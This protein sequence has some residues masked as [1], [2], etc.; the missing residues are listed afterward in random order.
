MAVEISLASLLITGV[1]RRQSGQLN[2]RFRLRS[3]F[4]FAV[5]HVKVEELHE[6]I[7]VQFEQIVRQ[8]DDKGGRRD[9]KGVE[10]VGLAEIDKVPHQKLFIADFPVELEMIEA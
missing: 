2:E 10:L 1:R 8:V 3:R 5:R 6:G 7:Q 4:L 9:V